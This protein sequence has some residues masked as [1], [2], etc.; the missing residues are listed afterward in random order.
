MRFRLFGRSLRRLGGAVVGSLLATLLVASGASAWNASGHMQV[1]LIA[2]KKM[3]PAT[4]ARAVELLRNHPRFAQDFEEKKPDDVTTPEQEQKWLFAHAATWADIAR[5]QRAFHHELWHYI[6]EPIFLSQGDREFFEATGIPHNV[7]RKL[8]SG[9]DEDDLNVVQ[10]IALARKRLS[11]ASTSQSDR[12]LYLTWLMHLVGDVHQPLHGVAFYSKHRF[13]KGD[14]GGNDFLVTGKRSL[15]ST[16]DAFLGTSESVSYLET[17]VAD[18]LK[19]PKLMRAADAAAGSLSVGDWVDESHELALSFAYDA[20]LV[21]VAEQVEASGSKAKP[22][23]NLPQRYFVEGKQH[24]RRRAVQ[25]G[26]RLAALL[27][28]LL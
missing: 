19:D 26:Y 21:A 2:Y 25:A 24:A 23:T 28:K 22:S 20:A 7:S 11:A 13:P 9:S 4:R 27:Q 5:K 18:Y 1:A 6:N 16:W 15:H 12:A 17:K 14:K 3:S 10:A 8:T